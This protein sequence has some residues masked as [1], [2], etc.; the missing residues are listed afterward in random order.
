MGSQKVLNFSSEK[1]I[2]SPSEMKTSILPQTCHQKL[3]NVNA[4]LGE[5]QQKKRAPRSTIIKFLIFATP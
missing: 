5:K 3:K 4:T 2:R 1:Q